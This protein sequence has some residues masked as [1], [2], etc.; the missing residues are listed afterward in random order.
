M[1]TGSA[2]LPVA[3]A[4]ALHG[5][6][7]EETADRVLGGED[8]EAVVGVGADTAA[9]F[10]LPVGFVDLGEAKDA[11]VV[12]AIVGEAGERLGRDEVEPE[13]G[14]A[15]E[16][17]SRPSEELHETVHGVLVGGVGPGTRAVAGPAGLHTG[18]G[19]REVL[20]DGEDFRVV[21][22]A[23]GEL[24]AGRDV[25]GEALVVDVPGLLG[26]RTGEVGATGG[27]SVA[28][29]RG[30]VG[31]EPY[32]ENTVA[33]PGA[34]DV[35]AESLV[36]RR[37]GDARGESKGGELADLGR[38]VRRDGVRAGVSPEETAGDSANHI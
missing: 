17:V 5:R 16:D 24:L 9:W 18:V 35:A 25:P 22:D 36:R 10:A 28:E 19:R 26:E 30:L 20:C 38:V 37:A 1:E 12:P 15:E 14:E 7:D 31:G 23:V 11:H 21:G 2:G 27:K 6:T 32:L 13:S 3:D 34:D 8:E 33:A 4:L 29:D